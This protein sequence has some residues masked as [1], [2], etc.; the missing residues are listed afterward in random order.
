MCT[1]ATSGMMLIDVPMPMGRRSLIMS[2]ADNE[3]EFDSDDECLW[4]YRFW[5][6]CGALEWGPGI[7]TA[8]WLLSDIV[9]AGSW[10]DTGCSGV[11]ADLWNSKGGG[12]QI[13]LSASKR[14]W[15]YLEERADIMSSFS[16]EKNSFFINMGYSHF[17]HSLIDSLIHWFIVFTTGTYFQKK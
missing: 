16:S 9:V 8:S 4:W 6:C 15:G 13:L 5:C 1:L 2:R 3:E 17:F 12:I 7:M 14:G 11:I 10:G